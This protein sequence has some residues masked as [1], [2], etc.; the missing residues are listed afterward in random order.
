M[1]RRK[2]GFTT[3]DEIKRNRENKMAKASTEKEDGKP[4][5]THTSW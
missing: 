2:R 3:E 1:S 4:I 5:D